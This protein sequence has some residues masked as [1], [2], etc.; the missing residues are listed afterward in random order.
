MSSTS[1]DAMA[2]RLEL[3]PLSRLQ[4]FAGNART[5]SAAQITALAASITEFG[6]CSPILVSSDAG[7]VAGHGRYAAAQQL[8]LTE[9]PVVVLDH[10]SEPQR[11]AYL[12]ADNRLAEQAGWNTEALSAELEQ[13]A[14]A[15]NLETLGFSAADMA[16]M[17][18]SLTLGS[19]EASVAPVDLTERAEPEHTGEGGSE[20]LLDASDDEGDADADAPEERFIFSASLTWD[21]REALLAAIT[22]AKHRWSLDATPDALAALAR[23]WLEN[24]TADS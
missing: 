5:H 9:V 21:D 22:A 6:F 7:I 24:N 12:I 4:P 8:G 14:G 23:D 3:W 19:L 20:P 18:D 16:R 11:R 15:F 1:P 13:L 2:Q 10:L 17:A